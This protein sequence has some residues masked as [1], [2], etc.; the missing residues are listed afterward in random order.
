MNRTA[1]NLSFLKGH[2]SDQV[3]ILVGQNRNVVGRLS[4]FINYYLVKKLFRLNLSDQ[5]S[6]FVGHGP[7]L[8]GHCPMTACY[9]QLCM[10]VPNVV[11]PKK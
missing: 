7:I 5:S 10:N 6:D 2:M 1:N 3:S 11:F 9:L 8:V 4:L